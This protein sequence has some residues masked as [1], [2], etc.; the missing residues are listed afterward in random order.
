MPRGGKLTIETA[1]THLDEDYALR[2][3]DVTPGDY[4]VLSVT[5]DGTGIPPDEVDKVFEPF[6]TTKEIGKGSGLGLSMVYGFMKQS[7]GHI[8]I[9]SEIGRGTTV[10]LYLPVAAPV[11]SNGEVTGK[12]EHSVDGGSETVL[13]VEDHADVRRV[14]VSLLQNLGYTVLEATNGS[15]A[16]LLLENHGDIDILFTDIVMPGGM[17]G[18]QVAKAAR[19]LRPGLP[20]VY[21]TGYA[22][23]A[24][25]RQGEVK[26]AK[27]LVT[28]PYRRDDL[29]HK[30]RQALGDKPPI[31]HDGTIASTGK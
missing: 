8:R 2:E 3:Q 26:A 27:N 5:D 7:G 17:D 18:T 20:V 15:E 1:H 28:K 11:V 21:A 16:L 14:A 24:V 31:H 9:Y 22:E 13:V 25:L 23:A 6:F 12:T 19:K 10:R 4:V 30:L 29:A